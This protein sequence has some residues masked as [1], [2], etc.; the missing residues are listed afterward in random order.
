[1]KIQFSL[2]HSTGEQQVET[3]R[4]MFAA[5]KALVAVAFLIN[6][7]SAW[8][9]INCR[10]QMSNWAILGNV[11]TCHGTS[12]VVGE[13]TPVVNIEGNHQSGM[14]NNRVLMLVLEN[15]LE[16]IPADILNFFPALTGLILP[17]YFSILRDATLESF[18]QTNAH[19]SSR[20]PWKFA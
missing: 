7:S 15:Q 9:I 20:N 19:N 14:N 5:I 18:V 4:K 3:S 8:M 16:L 13:G 12:R 17:V 2:Q 10:F 11:Y 1:M 6:S